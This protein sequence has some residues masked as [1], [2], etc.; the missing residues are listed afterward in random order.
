MTRSYRG[1]DLDLGSTFKK[2]KMVVWWSVTS[3]TGNIEVMDTY[4]KSKK[5]T[6]FSIAAN[7]AKNVRRYSA[8]PKEEERI[9]PPGTVFVV[10]SIL[11]ISPG[12]SMVQLKQDDTPSL[13]DIGEDIY[14]ICDPSTD[15]AD[16]GDEESY[17]TIEL[18]AGNAVGGEEWYMG[19]IAS[20]L[21][22]KLVMSAAPGAF[23]V[24]ESESKKGNYTLSVNG[25]QTYTHYRINQEGGAYFIAK[26]V[27][28][29]S[30]KEL[31]EHYTGIQDGLCI[32]LTQPCP[33]KLF[34]FE[35][36]PRELQFETA[37]LGEGEFGECRKALWGEKG[38]E[39]AVKVM[40]EKKADDGAAFKKTDWAPF[41]A[42]AFI[43]DGKAQVGLKH[44]YVV[45]LLGVVQVG[46]KM[47]VTEYMPMGPINMY[48][49]GKKKVGSPVPLQGLLLFIKQIAEGMLYLETKKVVHRY[50]AA[51]SI[52]V[53][54]D[55][56]CKIAN[57][58]TNQHLFVEDYYTSNEYSRNRGSPF[59]PL[60]WYAPECI[61]RSKFTS[62]SDVWSYGVCSWEILSHG[63]KPYSEFSFGLEVVAYAIEGNGRL[64]CPAICPDAM[65]SVLQECWTHKMKP[66]PDFAVV[67][68][69][70]T[71]IYDNELTL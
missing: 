8:F 35:I 48:L 44:E 34:A 5:K 31:I 40:L 68:Q 17:A 69:K 38:I 6:I 49:K 9:I 45:Q 13:I 36:D 1:V 33:M 27:M 25:G 18:E 55:S 28:F 70:V 21:A 56:I 15:P 57:L 37:L 22:E 58:K 23:L 64:A 11:T 67:L 24:R 14:A 26:R 10:E 20:A 43:A 3:V 32:Q 41:A 30:I 12:V 62:K 47:L 63:K 42:E 53:K 59:E 39:V 4:L 61:Y 16:G 2:G 60:A 46:E 19:K 66:R 51:R 29:T 52:L 65:Y 54:S 71:T 50:L 7:N